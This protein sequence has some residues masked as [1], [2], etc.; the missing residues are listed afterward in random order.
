MSN[1]PTL[2]KRVYCIQYNLPY[3]LL[4]VIMTFEWSYGV[5]LCQNHFPFSLVYVC[6]CVFVSKKKEKKEK[7][8]MGNCLTLLK[9][10]CCVQY[11]LSHPPLKVTM[12]FEWSCSMFLCQN[13]F[14]SP[15]CVY[16][17]PKEKK[18]P[19]QYSK[20]L[21]LCPLHFKSL[22]LF[23]LQFKFQVL[24]FN[25]FAFQALLFMHVILLLSLYLLLVDNVS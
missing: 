18:K 19:L 24:H 8:R 21:L 25:I 15:L 12:T 14:S 11:N 4:K 5:P 17:S 9:R 6:V 7:E 23:F 13:Q 2:L 3:S 22:L 20:L 1:C 10:V 16:V